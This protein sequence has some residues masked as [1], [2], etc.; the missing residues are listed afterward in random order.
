[1][2]AVLT[3]CAA[4]ADDGETSTTAESAAAIPTTYAYGDSPEQF[5]TLAVPATSGPHPVVVLIHGG[6]WR[7]AYGLDLMDPLAADLVGRGYAAWNIEYRRVGQPG[8]RLARHARGR[9][10][11]DRPARRGGGRRRP[12]P[13]TRERRRTFGG[14]PPGALGGR[15]RRRS[16]AARRAPIRSSTVAAA[17]GLAPVTNL[18]MGADGACGQRRGRRLPRRVTRGVPGSLRGRRA[19]PDRRRARTPSSRVTRTTS[20]RSGSPGPTGRET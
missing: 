7:A 8:R 18:R 20:C 3:S 4:S 13:D 12:R 11:G 9:G 1:M 17:V 14:R 10:G 2:A 19:E 15:P 5:A 16:N 6:F